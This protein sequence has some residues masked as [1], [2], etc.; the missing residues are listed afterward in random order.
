MRPTARRHEAL[1]RRL[2]EQHRRGVAHRERRRRAPHG[3]AREDRA[4]VAHRAGEAALLAADREQR[5]LLQVELP[6]RPLRAGHAADEL[7]AAPLELAQQ[8]GLAIDADDRRAL[9]R[10]RRAARHLGLVEVEHVLLHQHRRRPERLGRAQREA[11]VAVVLAA[12]DQQQ[13][14]R[15]RETVERGEELA[16]ARR[17]ERHADGDHAAVRAAVREPVELLAAHALDRD[18]AP[19]RRRE[20][21]RELLLVRAVLDQDHLDAAPAGRERGLDGDAAFDVDHRR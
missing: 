19:L 9:E 6:D 14:R 16:L 17:R 18:R 4:L 11:E 15:R 3:D 2:G 7:H 21:L 5:R 1:T 20:E 12:L 8:I 10:A 13:Q